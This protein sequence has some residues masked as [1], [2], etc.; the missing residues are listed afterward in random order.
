MKNTFVN[1]TNLFSS[2]DVVD[3]VKFYSEAG[4]TRISDA[5]WDDNFARDC[6]CTIQTPQPISPGRKLNSR[7][8]CGTD[9]NS[10]GNF[11]K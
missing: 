10:I 1:M 9:E 6:T 3:E 7:Y 2:G 8:F 5:A 11:R 4:R